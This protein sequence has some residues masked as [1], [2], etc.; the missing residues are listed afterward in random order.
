VV[1]SGLTLDACEARKR[2]PLLI[3]CDL[4]LSRMD[5]FE[6]DRVGD[7]G[8]VV[9]QMSNREG[10]KLRCGSAAERTRPR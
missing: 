2:A 10:G 7:A 8:S 5:P 6:R 4:T 1:V 3:E 9:Q